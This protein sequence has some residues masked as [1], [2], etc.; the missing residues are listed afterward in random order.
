MSFIHYPQFVEDMGYKHRRQQYRYTDLPALYDAL[1]K[2]EKVFIEFIKFKASI[3]NCD[4]DL[5]AIEK[6]VKLNYNEAWMNYYGVDAQESLQKYCGKDCVRWLEVREL[7]S[8]L[9]A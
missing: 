6:D 9:L 2:S 5:T 1:V 8:L 4:F 7:L 3:R